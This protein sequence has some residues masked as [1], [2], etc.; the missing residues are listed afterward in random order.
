VLVW[1]VLNNKK[2]HG[3]CI[4][5]KLKL[6]CY[7]IQHLTNSYDSVKFKYACDICEFVAV[8]GV[9]LPM[10]RRNFLYPSYK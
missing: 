10:F 4:K 6:F 1:C 9:L 3:T 2:M 5:I 8:T 7:N